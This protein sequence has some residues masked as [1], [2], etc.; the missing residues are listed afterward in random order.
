MA[1]KPTDIIVELDKLTT[2][3]E[4]DLLGYKS[5]RTTFPRFWEHFLEKEVT[6]LW[7]AE[8]AAQYRYNYDS[9]IAERFKKYGEY[10][11]TKKG[12]TYLKFTSE[13]TKTFFMIK[14]S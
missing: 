5:Y 7:T 14:Y 12:K 2:H 13:K 1:I 10:K 6:H 8:N 3:V 4:F 11:V 9:L